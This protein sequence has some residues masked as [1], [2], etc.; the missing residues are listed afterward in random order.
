MLL[1]VV[2]NLSTAD[3]A[4]TEGY[5]FLKYAFIYRRPMQCALGEIET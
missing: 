1:T 3:K 2:Y 4:V 5:F